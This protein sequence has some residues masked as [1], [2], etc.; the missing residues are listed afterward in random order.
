M[1]MPSAAQSG[2]QIVTL[3]PITES[4]AGARVGELLDELEP[5]PQA[6][7]ANALIPITSTVFIP[8]SLVVAP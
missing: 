6:A 4:D 3:E 2:H 1:D 5:D 8:I 7:M